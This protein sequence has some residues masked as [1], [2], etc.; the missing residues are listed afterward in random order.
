V[1]KLLAMLG[2]TVG[3]WIGWWAGAHDGLFVASL[4]SLVGTAGGI[5]GARWI[6]IEYF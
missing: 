4:L 1:G 6:T 2:A 5:Y 3:G